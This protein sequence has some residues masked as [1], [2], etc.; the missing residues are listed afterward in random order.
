MIIDTDGGTDDA[1]ALWWALTD[2]R[3]DLVG[4]LVT[5]GNVSRDTAAAN[6]CRLLNAAGRGD[7]PVALGA[8][9][10][11]GPTPLIG[12]AHHVHGTDG[13][14][15]YA[16]RWPTGNVTPVD[17]PAGEMLARCVAERPDEIDLVAIGPL[18]TVAGALA[19]DADIP[20]RTRS[21]TVMGGVVG[22]AGNSLP[23]GEAN[24]AHDPLAAERVVTAGWSHEAAGPPLL[25]GLDVTLRAW[26]DDESLALADEGR[27]VAARFVAGP[28]RAYTEYY[29]RTRQTATGNAACHDLLAVVAAVDPGIITDAPTLPLAVDTGGSAAWGATVADRRAVPQTT[30]P[31]FAPWNVALDLDTAAFQTALRSILV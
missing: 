13:L 28:L 7:V 22:R 19:D 17:E 16:D 12:L 26:V 4:I 14:G 29:A 6:V 2:P 23:V 27:T 3:I 30:R 9:G 5:W 8:D 25:V 20:A 10:P 18:S 31:G 11:I 24:V 1:V 21:L 15:G